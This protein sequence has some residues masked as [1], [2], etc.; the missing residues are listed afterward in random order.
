[1]ISELG[2]EC[3]AVAR[4]GGK[5]ARLAELAL[6]G[7]PVPPALCLTTDDHAGAATERAIGLWLSSTRP[8]R[9]ILRTSLAS[10]DTEEHARA[11]ATRSEAGVEP[12]ADRVLDRVRAL[13]THY[14]DVAGSVL[15]QEEAHC[16]FGGV[17]F[18][19][20]AETTI[21]VADTTSGVTAGQAPLTRVTVRDGSLRATRLRGPVPVLELVR[22][23]LPVLGRVHDHFG[24]A[25]D[26]EWGYVAGG[27]LVLQV[28]PITR[29]L[30]P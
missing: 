28:R 4:W 5:A 11:G 3:L 20:G 17:A 6:H 1:M 12:V 26:V 25:A 19:D 2:T 16:A 21:E 15:L 30:R 29:E 10:E 27:V 7:H 23:L 9:V 8:R 13:L 14:R 22:K 24:W 18:V